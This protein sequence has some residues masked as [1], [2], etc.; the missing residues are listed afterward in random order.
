M[1]HVI[2]RMTFVK[3]LNSSI[4]VVTL[5]ITKIPWKF[6]RIIVFF[7][8]RE[9]KFMSTTVVMLWVCTSAWQT[10]HHRP[11]Q[12]YDIW[13]Y[14][15]SSYRCHFFLL[16]KMYH[17]PWTAL[18]LQGYRKL[19]ANERLLNLVEQIIGPDIAGNPVWNLRTKTPQNEAT[20]VPWH[21]GRLASPFIHSCVCSFVRSLAPSPVRLLVGSSL[22]V[23]PSFV[24]S[25]SLPSFIHSLFFSP[26][27]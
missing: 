2:D 21:Q 10:F 9:P 14:R 1:G 19:W 3:L 24:P 11:A 15:Y 18:L 13:R 5:N 27:S 7:L 6:E 12:L 4:V 16:I 8:S 23:F 17:S 22:F 26:L 25:F 20:T